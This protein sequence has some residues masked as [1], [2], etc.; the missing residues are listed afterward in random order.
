MLKL[1]Y[2]QCTEGLSSHHDIWRATAVC[3]A[4]GELRMQ[5]YS[6]VCEQVSFAVGSNVGSNGAGLY[7]WPCT[8]FRPKGFDR[9]KGVDS[10][11]CLS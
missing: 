5:F 2:L 10:R 4:F 9:L 11:E 6:F 7:A 3:S 1:A 8:A